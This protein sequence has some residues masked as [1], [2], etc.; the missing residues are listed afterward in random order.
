MGLASQLIQ[1]N[2]FR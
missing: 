1:Q 2:N